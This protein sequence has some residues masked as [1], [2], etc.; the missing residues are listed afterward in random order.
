LQ[1]S[2]SIR[3]VHSFDSD[4]ANAIFV[5]E[6]LVLVTKVEFISLFIS[7]SCTK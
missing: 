3:A 4:L 5:L 7:S 2:S 1:R 6:A